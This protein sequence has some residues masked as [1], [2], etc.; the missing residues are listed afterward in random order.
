MRKVT[1]HFLPL[2]WV[3]PLVIE[4]NCVRRFIFNS[5]ELSFFGITKGIKIVFPLRSIQIVVLVSS[6]MIAKCFCLWSCPNLSYI[7]HRFST[8]YSTQ[9]GIDSKWERRHSRLG[10]KNL[11][12]WSFRSRWNCHFKGLRYGG[13]TLHLRILAHIHHR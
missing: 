5:S 12:L 10:R 6:L 1:T 7:C 13:L 2:F 11:R 8:R 9:L 4:F 3:L